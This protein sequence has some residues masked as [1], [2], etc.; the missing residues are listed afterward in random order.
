MDTRNSCNCPFDSALR[1][2]TAW[3]ALPDLSY[4]TKSSRTYGLIVKWDCEKE[5]VLAT[6]NSKMIKVWDANKEM[7]LGDW[8]TGFDCPATC[9]DTHR[10]GMLQNVELE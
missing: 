3:N 6:G 5:R 9:I 4:M 1:L 8:P 2:I 7:K 10:C